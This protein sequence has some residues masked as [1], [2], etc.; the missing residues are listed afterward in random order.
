MKH[1]Q[2]ETAL[3]ARDLVVIQLHGIDRPAPE[4]VILGIGTEDGAEKN[5]GLIT[6]GMRTDNF[7]CLR[8]HAISLGFC[9]RNFS[10]ADSVE[11]EMTELLQSFLTLGVLP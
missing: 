1:T 7:T 3:R 4:W 8:D 6:F 5:P 2:R 10:D 9:C 11:M